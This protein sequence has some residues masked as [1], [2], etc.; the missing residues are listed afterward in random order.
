MCCGAPCATHIA[1]ATFL[2]PQARAT[3]KNTIAVFFFPA[4]RS[5]E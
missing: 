3:T 4:A 5:T 2:L 1:R